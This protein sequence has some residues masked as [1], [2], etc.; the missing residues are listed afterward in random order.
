MSWF[1]LYAATVKNLRGVIYSSLDWK[2]FSEKLEWL[3]RRFRYR[4]LGVTK[5]HLK[6]YPHLDK[7]LK[8]PFIVL[9]YP[10]KQTER[11]ILAYQELLN[12]PLSVLEVYCMASMYVAPVIVLGEKSINGLRQLIVSSVR[13]S[14]TLNDKDYKLHMRIVD[15][16]TLDFYSW[17]TETAKETIETFLSNENWKKLLNERLEKIEKDKRRYWRIVS[18]SGKEVVLYFDLLP[19]LLRKVDKSSLE[20]LYREFREIIPATLAIVS[21]IVVV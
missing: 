16:T 9:S 15:Y 7:S 11:L 8:S 4:I 2:E 17:A 13:T 19:F 20:S 14:K 21:A 10:V 6:Q 18:E 1:H 5:E 3:R 12:L